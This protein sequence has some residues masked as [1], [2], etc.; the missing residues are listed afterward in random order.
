[1]KRTLENMLPVAMDVIGQNLVNKKNKVPAV[2]NGYISS[3]GASIIQMGLV[4]TL[5]VYANEGKER[6]KLL[7]AIFLLLKEQD[8]SLKKSTANDL[9]GHAMKIMRDNVSDNRNKRLEIR[10]LKKQIE[11]AAVALKLAI[12][13]FEKD[14]QNQ[15]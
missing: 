14:E 1:M 9:L 7:N 10:Q 5:V 2:Y 6:K 8:A 11:T 4:P 12:R 3:M 13:T 15:E